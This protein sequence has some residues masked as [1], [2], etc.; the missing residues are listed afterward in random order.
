M[1]AKSFVGFVGKCVNKALGS[2]FARMNYD[3]LI[4]IVLK[5]PS[6]SEWTLLMAASIN[7]DMNKFSDDEIA[8]LG[9]SL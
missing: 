4:D 5:G 8:V 9:G 2:H 1:A 3:R 7:V 6:K